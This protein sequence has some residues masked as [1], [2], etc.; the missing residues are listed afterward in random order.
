MRIVA[1][2]M[3]GW[4]R[5][6]T[7]G[8]AWAFLLEELQPD[9]ALLQ[10]AKLPET[11]PSEYSH[12]STPAMTNARFGSTILSRL[13]TLDKRWEDN[14]RGPMLVAE[15]SASSVGPLT[16]A[17]IQARV[18]RG[19]GTI[20][21]LRQSF[22]EIRPLL[23]KR[24]ILGGDLNTARQAHLAWPHTGHGDFWDDVGTWGLHE[25]LP[26]GGREQQSYWGH[27]A[28]NRPPT[29]GNTLQDDHVLLDAELFRTV[30]RCRI[31]DT[32]QVRELSDHGP[33]VVDIDG[34]APVAPGSS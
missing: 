30:K 6:G 32:R 19:V 1:W 16:I 34:S 25:P 17:S 26:L 12:E 29:L 18:Q 14:S 21:W 20:R 9:I 22:D 24:F 2:N 8:L 11:I 28:L 31:W 33:V 5:G 13:G 15:S 7:H 23:G 4:D 10:E 27:W 3:N